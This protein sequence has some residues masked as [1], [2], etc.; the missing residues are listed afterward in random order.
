MACRTEIDFL[1]AKKH[2]LMGQL[3]RLF[4]AVLVAAAC[5]SSEPARAASALDGAA[6]TWP[7]AL[8]FIGILLSIAIGPLLFPKTWQGHYGK[9]ALGWAAVTLAPLAVF[10]GTSATLAVFL[11]TMVAEYMSSFCSSLRFIRL[12]EA[13][14][15]RQHPREPAE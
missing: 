10:H 5:L 2:S 15:Y 7:W 14:C 3:M 8:P 12:P 13:F 9:I 11:H 4:I 6:M 1:P